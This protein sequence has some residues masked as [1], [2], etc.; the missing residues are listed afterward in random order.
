MHAAAVERARSLPMPSGAGDQTQETSRRRAIGSSQTSTSIARA[1]VADAHAGR[2][3]AAS[4]RAARTA[5][6][7]ARCASPRAAV[8]AALGE[9]AVER[10][11]AQVRADDG[12]RQRRLRSPA[13][14]CGVALAAS[15]AAAARGRAERQRR[16]SPASARRSAAAPR[17]APPGAMKVTP[18]GRPLRGEARR[19]RERAPAEQVDEVGVRAELRV[20]RRADRRRPR[21]GADGRARS[22]PSAGR[23]AARAR[24]L[25]RCAPRS[26]VLAAERVGRA[27]ARAPRR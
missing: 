7:A 24:A 8:G 4:C 19:H 15:P 20:A 10:Q 14:R 22:A 17:R 23:P 13:R 6:S 18:N 26:A 12:E 11:A 9:L 25:S 2:A 27:N 5:G 1:A 21:R 16:G 3:W